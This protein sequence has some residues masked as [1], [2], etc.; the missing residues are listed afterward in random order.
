MVR[1]SY[2]ADRQYKGESVP[3]PFTRENI[4]QAE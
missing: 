1:S 4:L 2:Y 3:K